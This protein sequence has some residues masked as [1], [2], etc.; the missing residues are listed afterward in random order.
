MDAGNFIVECLIYFLKLFEILQK[1]FVFSQK[2][3][4]TPVNAWVLTRD[5]GL[6]YKPGAAAVYAQPRLHDS[7]SKNYPNIQQI[8]EQKPS[9]HTHSDRSFQNPSLPL[10]RRPR[11]PLEY[12]LVLSALNVLNTTSVIAMPLLSV[13]CPQRCSCLA[14]VNSLSSSVS[15]FNSASQ[16]PTVKDRKGTADSLRMEKVKAISS[17]VHMHSFCYLISRR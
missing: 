8:D 17:Y 7:I 5:P 2:L 15:V 6:P 3:G 10:V 16:S 9:R 4:I 11:S 12:S 1:S 14:K 13:G